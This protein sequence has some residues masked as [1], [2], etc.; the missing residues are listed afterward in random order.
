MSRLFPQID[1]EMGFGIRDALSFIGYFL[2]ILFVLTF[3][4]PGFGLAIGLA[5]GILFENLGILDKVSPSFLF[6]SW[7]IIG[8]VLANNKKIKL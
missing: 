7:I 1:N 6:L 5:I 3:I 8:L 2:L 4:F